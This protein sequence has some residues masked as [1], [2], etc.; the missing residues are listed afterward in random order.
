MKLQRKL[1]SVTTSGG[2]T[3]RRS[4]LVNEII[5]SL[6][7]FHTLSSVTLMMGCAV[8]SLAPAPRRATGHVWV[9]QMELDADSLLS[10]PVAMSPSAPAAAPAEASTAAVA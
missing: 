3:D 7:V 10:N 4:L 5:V 8:T 1:R 9:D 6:A 2:P